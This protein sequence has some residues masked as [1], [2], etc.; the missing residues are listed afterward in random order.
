MNAQAYAMLQAPHLAA[1]A[2]ALEQLARN[3]RAAG[4]HDAALA[5]ERALERMRPAP[6][7]RTERDLEHTHTE[8]I[9]A[10]CLIH[11]LMAWGAQVPV[12]GQGPLFG[13]DA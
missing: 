6:A 8:T 1:R 11:A 2:S 13:V 10:Y 9:D 4:H 3:S 7:F 12:A 5:A